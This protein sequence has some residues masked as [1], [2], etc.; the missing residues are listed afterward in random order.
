MS[1]AVQVWQ[2]SD[3]G[4]NFPEVMKLALAGAPQLI[5]HR[6][7]EEVVVLSRSEYEALRPTLKEFLLHGGTCSDDDDLEDVIRR[8]RGEGV[9]LFGGHP[10]G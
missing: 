5:R 10:Q 1:D 7:G 6:N 9:S 3:A 8:N 4:N 2:A